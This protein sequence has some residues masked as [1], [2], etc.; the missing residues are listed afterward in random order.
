MDI[1]ARVKGILLSPNQEWPVV[2]NEPTTVGALYTGYIMPL[3]AIPP[4]AILIG[5]SLLFGRF[6]VGFGLIGA[7]VSWGFGLVG[8]YILALIAQWLAPKFDGEG[9]LVSALKLV[10]YSHTA[11]WVG[12]VFMIIPFLGILSFLMGLYGLYLLYAGATPTVGVPK[13]RAVVFTVALVVCAIVVFV[14]I[15]LVMRLIGLG[16]M[17]M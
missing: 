10:A 7:I 1:V 17:G 15:G 11:S 3:S 5:F 14:V 12:G 6:G 4:L 13:D 2:A 9:D 8:V 16:A